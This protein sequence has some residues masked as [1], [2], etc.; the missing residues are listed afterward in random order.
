MAPYT[1]WRIIDIIVEKVKWIFYEV[2]ELTK[3]Q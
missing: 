3:G 1:P 2:Q